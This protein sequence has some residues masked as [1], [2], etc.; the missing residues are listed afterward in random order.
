M[1]LTV[2]VVI[3]T[4]L[5]ERK[6]VAEFGDEYREYQQTVSMLFPW[7]WIKSELTQDRADDRGPQ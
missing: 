4:H 7:K 1:I 6:L 2:Y 5:E 3:G